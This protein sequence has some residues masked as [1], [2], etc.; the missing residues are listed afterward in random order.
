M[1]TKVQTLRLAGKSFVVLEQREYQRLRALEQAA[2]ETELPP[3]PEADKQG[4]TP[5]LEFLQI[6]IARDIAQQRLALGLTQ[7][8]LARLA[9]I[10]Q[11]TLCRLETGKVAPNVRTVDKLDRALKQAAR[12]QPAS[13]VSKPKS[14]K[15][16]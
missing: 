15:G 2:R 12:K 10:R 13:P 6:S 14:K 5:A 7:E 4:N 8:Q 3:L 1:S 11:E 16:G 9:G